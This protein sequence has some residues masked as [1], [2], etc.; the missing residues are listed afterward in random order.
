[1]LALNNCMKTRAGALPLWGADRKAYLDLL[2]TCVRKP[3]KIITH[4]IRELTG[5][6]LE[7]VPSVSTSTQDKGQIILS[8]PRRNQADIIQDPLTQVWVPFIVELNLSMS[9]F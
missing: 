2:Y 6:T 4:V 3:S 8:K 5:P 9:N 1:M 7:A